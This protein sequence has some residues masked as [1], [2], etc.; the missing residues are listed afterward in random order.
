[1]I[2]AKKT[3][4]KALRR[5][6]GWR[7]VTCIPNRVALMWLTEVSQ[8]AHADH[9]EGQSLSDMS[10]TNP[11]LT[12][13]DTEKSK[14]KLLVYLVSGKSYLL[15]FQLAAFLIYGR[16]ILVTG[17]VRG[18]ESSNTFFIRS[19]LICLGRIFMSSFHLNLLSQWLYVQ[20]LA[21]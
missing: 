3:K 17:W 21:H 9:T 5:Q 8:S 11:F 1:M 4:K 15:G 19:I 20:I 13:L 7:R 16:I 2:C 14:I 18:R 10:N 12:D 6:G